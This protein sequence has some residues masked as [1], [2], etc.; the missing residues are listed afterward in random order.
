MKK[1]LT[2]LI[3]IGL[4]IAIAVPASVSAECAACLA[5]KAQARAFFFG[6]PA[7]GPASTVPSGGYGVINVPGQS[8]GAEQAQDYSDYVLKYFTK[9]DDK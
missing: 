1:I 2:I 6:Q 3:A 5:L 7:P 4:L 9:S 8:G